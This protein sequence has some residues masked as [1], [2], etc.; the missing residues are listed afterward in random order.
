MQKPW[1]LLWIL[2]IATGGAI[3]DSSR[4]ALT[5]REELS[6]ATAQHQILVS[7][8]NSGS[9]EAVLVVRV[10]DSDRPS[11]AQRV[12]LERVVPPGRFEV[13]VSLGG[14]Q[15]PNGQALSPRQLHQVLAFAAGYKQTLQIDSL[16]IAKVKSLPDGATGWDLGDQHSA[17]WPGFTRLT[18]DSPMLQGRQIRAIDRGRHQQ[19]AEAMT[20]DGIRG[21]ETLTLPLS[22][23]DWEVTL[24]LHDRGEWEYLPFPLQRRITANDQLVFHSN[25]SPQEWINETYLAGLSREYQPGDE[26]WTAYG[27]QPKGRLSFRV[28]LAEPGLTLRFNGHMPEAGYLAAVLAEPVSDFAVRKR[29]EAD[30]EQWWQRNWPI[31]TG[32]I[33][34]PKQPRLLPVKTDIVMAPGTI[35]SLDLTLESRASKAP[36]LVH[37]TLPELDGFALAGTLRWGRW[38][39]RRTRLSS[40][41]LEPVDSHLRGTSRIPPGNGLP[42]SLKIE[43]SVPPN[44]PA[45]IYQGELRIDLEGYRLLEPLEVRVLEVELPQLD[46]P[47]G[48]YLERPAQL[49]WFEGQSE[50]RKQAFTCDLGYL[51]QLGLS[52]LSPGLV[53]P[54]TQAQA[55]QLLE[56]LHLIKQ[57]GFEHTLVAYGPYERLVGRMGVH[58][59]IEQLKM[60]DRSIREKNLPTLAW[61]IADEPSN[62][63]RRNNVEETY[64]YAQSFTPGTLLAGHLNAPE[65]KA[66]LKHFNLVLLNSGFGVDAEQVAAIQRAGIQTWFYN[67]ENIR[68][69]SGFYLWKSGAE[70]YLQ[71]HGRMPTAAPFDPT[72]G[73]EDDAQFLYPTREPCPPRHDV[74]RRLYD[75]VEGIIDLRWM[76]W[77]ERQASKEP[78]AAK[79]LH[80]MTQR[81]P[82]KWQDMLEIS[83]ARLER[84]RAEIVNL[85]R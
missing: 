79:L 47:V 13:S 54:T 60:V 63:G 20:I 34:E 17:I 45:G 65:D 15:K 2:G 19:A 12:N 11:Y 16:K 1:A 74:D 58:G 22:K 62:P 23:G 35:G 24:W 83:N 14:L 7:G 43:V 68:A 52:G 66:L 37:L 41:L 40:T 85:A 82:G 9:T 77:L 21:I 39:L 38:Q 31:R 25:Q 70:G 51:R 44:A 4:K 32:S 29:V 57:A 59:A 72:D 6:V 84:W 76:L 61:S 42:R 81:I 55:E 48:I 3:A 73:R 30:R 56:Q 67:M 8:T 28:Q 64:R 46:R 78:A 26:V 80:E 5:D 53:T 27:E 36:P 49:T 75:M 50:A 71:W 18:P 69:S 33:S 10:D